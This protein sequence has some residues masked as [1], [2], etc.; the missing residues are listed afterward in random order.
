MDAPCAQGAAGFLGA[1]GQIALSD[2]TVDLKNEYGAVMAVS[3][4]DQPLKESGKILVQ[5]MTEEK[6]TGW[7]TEPTRA[8][9]EQGKGEVDVQRIIA[10][11]GAPI[12]VRQ[13]AGSMIL[14][15]P[16]VATLTVTPL[17]ANGYAIGEPQRG[18]PPLTL[19]PDCMYYVISKDK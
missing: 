14:K 7:K 12:L 17:D 18:V 8:E 4:D 13:I 6:F 15:R 3:L 11:G 16:D 2:I 5:V 1:A 9:L 10:T 19:T